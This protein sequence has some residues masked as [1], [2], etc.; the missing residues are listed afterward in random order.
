MLRIKELQKELR[1]LVGYEGMG[2]GLGESKSGLY[3][4]GQHCMLDLSVLR[5]ICPEESG[6]EVPDW[7]SNHRY[8]GGEYV[9]YL[10]KRYVAAYGSIG[11]AP[12]DNPGVWVEA[13]GFGKWLWDM[14]EK[15]VAKVLTRFESDK[16]LMKNSKVLLENKALYETTGRLSDTIK[17][18]GSFV[19]FEIVPPRYPSVSVKIRR[20]GLQMKGTG[21]VK[22][23]LYHSSCPEPLREVNVVRRRN[24]SMEWAEVEDLYLTYVGADV[25]AGGSYYLVYNQD[26]LPE[27]CE[28]VNKEYDWSKAPCQTCN[29]M[30]YT[31]WKQW[32]KLITVTPFKVPVTEDGM[33]W[34][35]EDMMPTVQSSYGI[36][37]QFTVTCDLTNFIRENSME[38]A[39]VV[40]KQLAL[41]LL[42]VAYYNPSCRVNIN[43]SNGNM[44]NLYYE[45]NGDPNKNGTGMRAEL[46]RA[47]KSVEIGT[48]G[49]DKICLPCGNRGIR[50]KTL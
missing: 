17:N 12:K 18:S 40:A 36:N 27:G 6:E 41:D 26:E 25:D 47:Y 29:K 49:L 22:V 28:A 13:D 5:K 39:N 37:I 15:A 44:N 34:D 50:I 48:R 23:Y 2:G 1:G 7:K 35:L 31:S 38:F 8:V 30:D 42:M 24:G 16:V 46:E 4:Q 33:L 20:I 10:G 43:M 45:I 32:S 3:V 9:G 14:R 21:T 11:R 19:G